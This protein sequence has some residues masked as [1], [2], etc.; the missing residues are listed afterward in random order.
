M[1]WKILYFIIFFIAHRI[2]TIDWIPT[3]FDT[4]IAEKQAILKDTANDSSM[5]INGEI[6]NRIFL[7]F[8]FAVQFQSWIRFYFWFRFWFQIYGINLFELFIKYSDTVS[9]TFYQI[10]VLMLFVVKDFTDC[11]L[12]IQIVD[13]GHSI[14]VWYFWVSCRYNLVLLESFVLVTRLLY[15]SD[16]LDDVLC[17][18]RPL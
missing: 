5:F 2:L 11:W 14:L 9:L 8:S 10:I 15:H 17:E 7:I 12:A 3:N 16:I 18:L 6:N 1:L 13:F 4:K